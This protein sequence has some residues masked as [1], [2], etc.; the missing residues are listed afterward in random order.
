[1]TFGSVFS[2]VT[3]AERCGSA[4]DAIVRVHQTLNLIVLGKVVAR[5][6]PTRIDSSPLTAQACSS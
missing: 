4:G 2:T 5:E 6:R 3:T 1:M